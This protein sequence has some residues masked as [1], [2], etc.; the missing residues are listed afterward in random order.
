M[1]IILCIPLMISMLQRSS[2]KPYIIS[3]MCAAIY[4]IIP[5]IFLLMTNAERTATMQIDNH[6]HQ[7]DHS[8]DQPSYQYAT[9]WSRL[10]R[11]LHWHGAHHHHAAAGADQAL[12]DTAE[13]IRTV[14][15]ALVAL[16]LTSLIQLGIVIGSGSVALLADTF[17]NIGD[18]LNS[19]PLLIAFYLARRAATRR[20]T[21]G[22]A[23]AEDVA[24][25]FI[26]LSIAVS[27]GVILWESFQKLLHPE[28]LNNLG[29]VAAAAV[30][31]F[32]GNEA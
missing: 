12:I 7:N 10:S 1:A 2:A 20:Y 24:G 32:L 5:S 13:G 25:I 16:A 6:A 28:P 14:W 15:F 27:A 3:I 11:L 22:F 21:Y 9:I 8:H 26:V 23:R 31:G 29:W 4:P 19:I 17:H 18:F 30:I